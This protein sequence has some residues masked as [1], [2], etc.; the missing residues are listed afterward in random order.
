MG[1]T[2][3]EQPFYT[4]CFALRKPF[5]DNLN[6]HLTTREPRGSLI[7]GEGFPCWKAGEVLLQVAAILLRFALFVLH[8]GGSF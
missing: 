6:R 7:Q 8:A 5:K 4:Q 3:D 2:A 1:T